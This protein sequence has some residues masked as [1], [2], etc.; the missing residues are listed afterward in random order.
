MTARHTIWLVMR[1]EMRE[2]VRGRQF[3]LST[4]LVLLI[5]GAIVLVTALTGSKNTIAI[6]IVRPTP[7]VL[8]R[9]LDRAA[10]PLRTHVSLHSYPTVAA[11]RD[12][13]AHDKVAVAFAHNGRM[14]LVR[15]DSNA[16]AI[17]VA[18][19]GA[20]A[21]FLAPQRPP[22]AV[23]KVEP[24][25]GGSGGKGLAFGAAIVLYIAVSM[26]GSSVLMSVIQEKSGRI[27]EVLLAAL[28]PRHLLAGKVAGIGLLGLA[29]I[30]LMLAGAYAARAAGLVSLPALG[31]TLPLVAACF[32]CGFALYAVGFAA[33]GAL[34]SRIE[35]ATAAAMP[36]SLTMLASY[37]LSLGALPKPDG[38]LATVVTLL[39]FSAPFALP[40]RQAATSI[41]AWEY[42]ASFG[43]MLLA[44]WLLVRA[45][46]R[47]YE[48]GLLRSGPR[49]TFREALTA[50]RSGS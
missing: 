46:G 16:T 3:L 40:A 28:R 10:A 2:A 21:A 13:V 15:S 8:L 41:P 23:A 6:G 7:A 42:A 38:A 35:D 49:V 22:Y 25:N 11:A 1:R 19:A 37:I 43:L 4:V 39:P 29:Q 45:A 44:I 5:L 27:V 9:D 17:A 31:R 32:L 30:A 34:V 18:Q 48:L 24:A 20:R 12:A 50:V 14:L 47:V 26:F 33:V 36:V